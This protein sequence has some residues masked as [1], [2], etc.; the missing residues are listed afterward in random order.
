MASSMRLRHQQPELMD[1]PALDRQLH[2]TALASLRRINWWSRVGPAVWQ[3]VSRELGRPGAEFPITV[4]D[5]GSGGGDLALRLATLADRARVP[6]RISGCD[7]SP[8]AIAFACEQAA[9]ARKS[10]VTFHV[11]D[12]L[13]E[14]FPD[15]RYDVVLCSLFL[16]HFT[17]DLAVGLL[18]RMA[19]AAKQMV[20][21]DDLRRSVLGFWLAWFG[22]RLLTRS[23]VVHI[24]GPRSV[25]GAY[26]AAEA[27]ELAR[28]A[29]LREVTVRRRWPE[30]YLLV[31]RPP[32]GIE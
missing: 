16:H 27:Q 20:L 28:R 10:N 24:D 3:I 19:G 31:A 8:T 32:D 29:G 12:V 18:R 25:E 6:I 15:R 30:R 4:L 14:P 13:N 9:N 23:R 26:T 1:D 7:V 5:V 21:V 17:P 22:C 2:R 11:C